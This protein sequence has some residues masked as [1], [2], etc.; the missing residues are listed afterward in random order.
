VRFYPLVRTA[1]LERAQD[2]APATTLYFGQRFDFDPSLAL[3]RP[4]FL[5]VGLTGALRHLIQSPPTHLEVPEPL[6]IRYLPHSFM[7]QVVA[8]VSAWTRGTRATVVTYA[9]ENAWAEGL[10][11][12][13][14]Q[15]QLLRRACSLTFRTLTKLVDRI[16]FGTPAAQDSYAVIGGP[17]W[18]HTRESRLVPALPSPCKCGTPTKA[19]ATALFLGSLEQRKGVPE[20]LQAWPEV[21]SL[22][23]SAQLTILGKGPLLQEVAIWARDRPE[24]RVIVDPGRDVIHAEL[25]RHHALVL[26]SQSEGNWREQLGLPILEGLAHGCRIVTTSET[27]L[28]QWLTDHSHLVLS[29][30]SRPSEIARC[31]ALALTTSS[32]DVCQALPLTDG[33]VEADRW[34]LR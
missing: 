5:R 24:V 10:P 12:S 15:S 23:P 18:Q 29:P 6:W 25:R 31:I 14:H 26:L 33:R 17:A 7:L 11:Q 19:P 1:H 22:L 4:D 27:G 28:A 9:I 21:S 32:G 16:A 20:L 2:L 30:A 8:K 3:G 13:L 34:L